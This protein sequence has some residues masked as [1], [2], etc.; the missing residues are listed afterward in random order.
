[1]SQFKA[2]YTINGLSLQQYFQSI[3][4]KITAMDD[5]QDKT[6]EIVYAAHELAPSIPKKVIRQAFNKRKK[7]WM[8]VSDE[9]F[10]RLFE[11]E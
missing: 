11:T 2:K 10:N 6:D 1:M 5:W 7:K 3:K 8:T 9:V 4:N